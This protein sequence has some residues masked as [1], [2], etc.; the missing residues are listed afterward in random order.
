MSKEGV[1]PPSTGKHFQLELEELMNKVSDDD[2][3][4]CIEVDDY[5]EYEELYDTDFDKYYV[6]S[7]SKDDTDDCNY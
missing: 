5:V 4:D 3:C 2:E 1:K 6:T 7:A